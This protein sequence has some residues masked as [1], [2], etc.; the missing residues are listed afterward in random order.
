MELLPGRAVRGTGCW[1][2]LRSDGGSI[3]WDAN[4]RFVGKR[5]PGEAPAG[6]R[7]KSL[8]IDL[9]D[10]NVAPPGL[11]KTNMEAI[12]P[13]TGVPGYTIVVPPAL[14]PQQSRDRG[15]IA[16]VKLVVCSMLREQE[17]Q[18]VIKL[19][20]CELLGHVGGHRRER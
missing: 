5:M 1:F 17:G 10:N 9:I 19:W 11:E 6:R 16:S 13:G 2:K 20:L 7:C 12:E 8:G 4:P 14:R 15:I 3:A 18:Q